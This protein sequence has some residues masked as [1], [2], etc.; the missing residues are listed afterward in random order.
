MYT[1]KNC[2]NCRFDDISADSCECQPETNELDI[3]VEEWAAQYIIHDQPN[4]H[5]MPT[6]KTPAYPGFQRVDELSFAKGV[7]AGREQM[8]KETVDY[9][10]SNES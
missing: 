4:G 9:I 2:W 6:K 7:H 10:L 8:A 5:A 1:T 3:A